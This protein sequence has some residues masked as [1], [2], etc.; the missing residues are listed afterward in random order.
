MA[1]HFTASEIDAIDSFV[2]ADSAE[3]A[4]EIVALGTFGSMADDPLPTLPAG[5]TW[6]SKQSTKQQ[7]AGIAAAAKK[8]GRRSG[9][10][11]MY[12]T[13]MTLYSRAIFG[14]AAYVPSAAGKTH[15]PVNVTAL[16]AKLAAANV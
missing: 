4:A 8:D 16:L 14:P 9:M 12:Y 11:D 3:S 7:I 15:A 5:Y 6:D 13:L 1:K 2:P 10:F